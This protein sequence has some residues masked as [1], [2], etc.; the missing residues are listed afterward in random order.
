[1]AQV[2]SVTQHDKRA[3]SVQEL[4]R[5]YPLSMGFLWSEIR[6]GSLRVRRFGRRVLVLKEDWDSYLEKA[7][8]NKPRN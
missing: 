6:R 5:L 2:K 3:F 7:G 1:M 4:T 8:R